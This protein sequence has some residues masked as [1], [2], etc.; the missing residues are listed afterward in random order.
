MG[1]TCSLFDC[2][3]NSLENTSSTFLVQKPLF[4]QRSENPE[5]LKACIKIQASWKGF[6]IRKA[7]KFMK[8]LLKN[9]GN[10]RKCRNF[11]GC[12]D[13][14]VHVKSSTDLK[15]H[16]LES[17]D[18]SVTLVSGK[19][20]KKVMDGTIYCGDWLGDSITGFGE[21]IKPDGTRYQ[22]FFIS[23]K[24]HGFGIQRLED[25]SKV[26]GFW[27]NGSL[28]GMEDVEINDEREYL[29]NLRNVQKHNQSTF[30]ISDINSLSH[31][32]IELISQDTHQ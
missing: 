21:E 1:N 16:F 9:R 28:T 10:G 12:S 20:W 23:G 31:D 19:D 7:T 22:G 30:R 29:I 8:K 17:V 3:E 27:V 32:S 11:P 6:K 15:K 5:V 14:E 2:A 25:G 13:D 18:D 26:S 24:K 4:L